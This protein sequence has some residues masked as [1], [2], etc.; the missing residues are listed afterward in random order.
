MLKGTD[1]FLNVLIS[2]IRAKMKNC[3]FLSFDAFGCMSLFFEI[4]IYIHFHLLKYCSEAK[5]HEAH[6][7]F[8][9]K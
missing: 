1:T 9:P 4:G 6:H 7:S 8:F 2:I 3:L 5:I